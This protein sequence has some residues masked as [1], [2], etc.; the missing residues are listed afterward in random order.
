[1]TFAQ[2]VNTIITEHLP[3]ESDERYGLD[4][5]LSAVNAAS[6]EIASAYRLGR[7]QISLSLSDTGVATLSS[8][9]VAGVYALEDVNAGGYL[10]TRKDAVTADIYAFVKG[11]PRYYIWEPITPESLL[12]IPPPKEA[13]TLRLVALREMPTGALANNLVSTTPLWYGAYAPFHDLVVLKA[14]KK[15][16]DAERLFEESAQYEQRLSLREAEFATHLQGLSK[17]TV[18]RMQMQGASA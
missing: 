10:V 8:T 7:S 16:F 11:P 12:V 6:S 1:M 2:A 4:V 14:V 13:V 15:L 17:D 5:I 18:M 9:Q 3:D